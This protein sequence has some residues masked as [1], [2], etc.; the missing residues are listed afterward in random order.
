MINTLKQLKPRARIV[1]GTSVLLLI[2]ALIF[3]VSWLDPLV[4]Y[5]GVKMRNSELLTLTQT[6][7]TLSG[8]YCA[9]LA[10]FSLDA[11]FI[12]FDSKNEIDQYIMRRDEVQARLQ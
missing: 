10:S 6:D 2:F 11:S 1:I 9:Q 8:I 4:L 12:C 5:Y 3:V 7:P